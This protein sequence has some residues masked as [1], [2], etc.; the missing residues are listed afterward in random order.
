MRSSTLVLVSLALLTACSRGES[1]PSFDLSGSTMG[2]R[3]NIT[4]IDP[5]D[6]LDL[7][8]LRA[9]INERL[10]S[11][12]NLASTYRSDSQLARLNADLSTEWVL[13]SA[14]LCEMLE[15][16]MSVTLASDGAFDITVGPLVNL[17]GFGPKFVDQAIPTDDEIAAAMRHVGADKLRIDCQRPALRKSTPNVYIDLS[18][19][20]KGFAVDEIAEMLDASLVE[21]YLVEIGGELRMRGLNAAN[22]TYTIAVEKPTKN[23]SMTYVVLRVTDAAIATSGDYRNFF[24]SNGTRYSHAI[25]PRTGWPVQH[26]LVGVTVIGESTAYADAMATALLVL[27]PDDGLALA[28]KLGLAALFLVQA[29]DETVERPSTEFA[30][31][32]DR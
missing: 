9:R 20:A 23:A 12:E 16:A 24:E 6:N 15:A 18:G 25:N 5:P 11:V 29:G 14:E 26:A 31:A 3:F 1:L 27:G 22:E 30:V 8:D 10:D 21:N 13:V 4:L 19:W 28:E 7:D 17:W 32:V 2:T